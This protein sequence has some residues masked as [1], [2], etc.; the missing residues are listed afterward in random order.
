MRVFRVRAFIEEARPCGFVPVEVLVL[1]GHRDGVVCDRIERSVRLRAEF[2]PLDHRRPIA[3]RVHL[4]ARQHDT[5]RTL[6]RPRRQH[7]Q[8]HLILRPQARA[9][10][11]RP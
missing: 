3:E 2:D 4:L 7:G 8:N 9:E 10:R 6:Q 11:R 1:R 5:N